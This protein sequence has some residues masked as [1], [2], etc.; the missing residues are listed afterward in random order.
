MATQA[1]ADRDR[2][3]QEVGAEFTSSL[4]L[5]DVL[6]KVMD[7]VIQLT[8]AAR[9]FIVLVDGAGGFEVRVARG[10]SDEGGEFSGSTSVLEAVIRE[11]RAILTTDATVD[12]R[13]KNQQSVLMQGLRSVVAVPLLVR[14]KCTGALYIDN[15][16]RAGLFQEDDRDLLQAIANV[17]AIAIENARLYTELKANY[18]RAE[19]LRATFERY[20]NKSVTDWVLAA[21]ERG[22]TMLPGARTRVTMLASDIAG[23]STL[24]HDYEAEDIVDLLNR[25]FARMVG[26]V[27]E[28]GGNIDKFQGDGLLVVFGAPEPLEDSPSRAVAAALAM[29]KE[30]EALNVERARLGEPPLEVGIGIDTGFVVAGNIG[31]ERRLEYTVIG[32]P[33]NNAAFLSKLRPARILISQNTFRALEGAVE[34][35]PVEPVV[36]KGAARPTPVYRLT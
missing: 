10:E 13:F 15:P 18:D 31:S 28:H 2:V 21:P 6:E 24:S 7:R 9:G 20:V 35:E 11:S 27:L 36:L 32:V 26:V 4:D 29:R 12:E 25:Y 33:V 19:F 16:L 8:K 14:G 34:A 5:D 17:A 1:G 23:F 3:L 30:I 22:T